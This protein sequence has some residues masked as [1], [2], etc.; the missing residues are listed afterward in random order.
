MATDTD[1]TELRDLRV[2]VLDDEA[3]MRELLKRMLSRLKVAAVIE[4]ASGAEALHQL[5]RA[6]DPIDLVI[7]DWNMAEMSGMEFFDAA[8]RRFALRFL[9]LTGR[10]DA[11]LVLTAKRAGIP[12]YIV[13]PVTQAELKA[14]IKFVMHRPADGGARLA[15]P[16][17]AS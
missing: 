6:A 17:A 4:A 1:T 12:A 7:C 13:K 10:A 3:E 15:A 2:L 5:E 14:K 11:E 9:M 8:R 16:L